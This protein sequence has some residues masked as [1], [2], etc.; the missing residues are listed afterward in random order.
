MKLIIKSR[1]LNVNAT[2]LTAIGLLGCKQF[3]ELVQ[4]V[5]MIESKEIK[6]MT[7][8]KHWYDL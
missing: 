7:K 4:K 5:A 1:T 8:T 2:G 6:S 3:L